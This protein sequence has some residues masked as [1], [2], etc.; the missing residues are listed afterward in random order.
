MDRARKREFVAEMNDVFANTG[1][2]VVAHYAGLT[3]A[4]M[5]DLR[6][7]MGAVGAHLKVVKNRL[8]K[9]ALEGTPVVGA[10]DLFRGP[11]LVAYSSDPVAAPKI[12]ADFAKGNEHLVI[13]G[14]AMGSTVLDQAGINALAS[15]P[16]LDELRARLIGLFQ[17]PATRVACVLQAPACQVAR[18]LN[19]R[20]EKSDAA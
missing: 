5:T 1:I 8:A 12:A 7:R 17:T 20:A 13:L 6:G 10:A 16:S 19:A 4:Q 11:T 9:R 2:I 14:G 3:V 15:L 18:V